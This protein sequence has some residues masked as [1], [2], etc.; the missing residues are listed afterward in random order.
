[1]ARLV[2]GLKAKTL[3]KLKKYPDLVDRRALAA[4]HTLADFDDAVTAPVHGFRSAADYWNSSSSASFLPKIRRPTLLINAKD[5]PFLPEK[6][7]P[8]AAV[9][10][11]RFLTA[12]FTS[13][14]GHIGFLAGGPWCGLR[15]PQPRLRDYKWCGLLWPQPRLRDY[16]WC[17]LLWPQPLAGPWPGRPTGWAED[18]AIRFLESYALSFGV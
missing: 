4:V 9:L 18:R 3:A 10:A 16:K 15:W 11:N 13:N 17:G 12:E 2:R 5:D 1:M 6:A 7:L 8:L 14:G